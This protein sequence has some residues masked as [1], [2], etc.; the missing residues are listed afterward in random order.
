MKKRTTIKIALCL[1]LMLLFAALAGCNNSDHE[2][3]WGEWTVVKKATCEVGETLERVCDCG[4]RESKISGEPVSHTSGGEWKIMKEATL[5]ESGKKLQI[6]AECNRP[7]NEKVIPALSVQPMETFTDTPP[8][9]TR[10]RYGLANCRNLSGSPVVVL[11]FV[12]DEESS[13][14]KSEVL[15]FMKDHILVGLNYLEESA[16]EWGVDLDFVIESHSTALSGYEVKYEGVVWSGVSEN[17]HYTSDL[18]EKA[19]ADIAAG[20]QWKLYSYYKSKYPEDDIIFVNCLNKYGRSYAYSGWE[21]NGYI[22][23]CEYSVIFSE[24][25]D[26]SLD[27]QGTG[28]ATVAHEILHLFGAEDYYEPGTRAALADE[29]YPD[30]IM[31]ETRDDVS[32]NDIGDLTAYSIGWTDVVPEICSNPKWWQ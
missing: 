12:D 5:R 6:C 2:H 17:G 15:T 10:S 20:S 7:F 32:K 31:L 28:A 21:L 13:W 4:E 26:Y 1:L 14:S 30:D 23:R 27:E 9:P 16:K 25:Y 18:L 8:D 3:E 29:F 19:A 11:I 24:Y 22:E